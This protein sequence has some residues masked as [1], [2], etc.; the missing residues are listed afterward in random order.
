MKI[1]TPI[2]HLFTDDALAVQILRVS[3]CLEQR[4]HSPKPDI[5]NSELYHSDLQLI[6]PFQNQN[7]DY[8]EKIR[9]DYSNL[10]CISFHM[11]SCYAQP[12]TKEG[13]FVSGKNLATYEEMIENSQIN[14]DIVRRIFGKKVK[15]LVENNNFYPTS[16]YNYIANPEFIK[17][18]ISLND[19]D[20][21]YDIAHAKISAHNMGIS[22]DA[23]K[24][25]L[26][27]E[28]ISQVHIC[29]YDVNEDNLA[30]DAHKVPDEIEFAEV[31]NLSTNGKLKYL[32][33]EYY[34]SGEVLI[35]SI[36]KLKTYV[37]IS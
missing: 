28:E 4:D 25:E 23:Y 22:Y 15:V 14:T 33:I 29:K 17:E 12:T 32:T 30:F 37:D 26:P 1:A 11:A 27:L 24:S 3:D 6:H 35:N 19:L 7:I 8:L 5:S 10:R 21:L 2:S 20:F 31:K 13:I 18:V 34:K 36:E 16:A 9:R